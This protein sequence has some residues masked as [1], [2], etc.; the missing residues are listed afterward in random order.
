[1][2]WN[3]A[4]LIVV[5]VLL[6]QEPVRGFQHSATV[7]S[8]RHRQQLSRQYAVPEKSIDGAKYEV[9]L[10][11]VKSNGGE[12]NNKITIQKSSQGSGYG[13]FTNGEVKEGEIIFEI[14][15]K[16]CFTLE[17]ALNDDKFGKAFKN[18]IEKAGPGGNTVVMAGYMA[19][20]RLLGKKD[21]TG[22]S[23]WSAYFDTLPW[24]RGIN[25]QEHVLFWQEEKIEELLTGSTC[26]VEAKSLRDEVGLATSIMNKVL[27][28]SIRVARGED[29][30]EGGFNINR[31]LP[32]MAKPPTPEE[33]PEGFP[34]AMKGAFVCLLTR[35][36]QDEKEDGNDDEEKL[37]PLL[38]MLQHSD[39][40]N[41][42]H[43][44]RKADGTVEVRARCDIPTGTELFNQ[45][46]SEEEETM[47][48]S[49]FFTRFGFVPG[50]SE[51][52]EN[53]LRD[54]SSIF[55]PQKAEI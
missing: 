22:T 40:P 17:A 37:V 15:R 38:D 24:E 43:A 54:K 19:K 44:M 12:I 30:D 52:M 4:L 1:M 8:H 34:E 9:L 32:W 39:T 35:A 21:A 46:R 6:Q 18:L 33:P 7:K 5:L 29:V 3:L 53:L 47:P 28:P 10:D 2:Y 16:A 49:R 48:Y 42:R 25:N 13:A 26:Y 27:G 50:I 14:P 11:W 51:D 31:M 23:A 55:Y 45:Y 41:V 36:F 20:E